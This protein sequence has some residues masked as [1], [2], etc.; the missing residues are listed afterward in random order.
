LLSLPFFIPPK[1]ID[2]NKIVGKSNFI[3]LGPISKKNTP[4]YEVSVDLFG[5]DWAI[6]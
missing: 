2:K 4:E 5:F 6:N 1:I 3:Y